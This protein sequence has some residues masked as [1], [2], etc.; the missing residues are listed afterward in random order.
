MSGG[1][2]GHQREDETDALQHADRLASPA[3][4]QFAG[5]PGPADAGEHEA[6][7]HRSGEQHP[8]AG[9]LPA[10]REHGEHQ[11]QQRVGL[12]VEARTEAAREP[13]APCEPAIDAVEHR[14]QGRDRHR[15]PRERSVRGLQAQ[16][17]QQ[18]DARR[19]R[20]RDTVGRTERGMRMTA[21]EALAQAEQQQRARRQQGADCANVSDSEP[22][23]TGE[24]KRAERTERNGREHVSL[25][26]APAQDIDRVVLAW[27]HATRHHDSMDTRA[28]AAF[29]VAAP[30]RGEIR[31]ET[32]PAPKPDEVL[33]RTLYSGI[34]RG[35]ES[36][37]FAGRVPRSEWNRMRAPFQAGEFPAPVKYGY[38]SVGIVEQGPAG[39]E[40]ETVFCLFPHQTRYVVPARAVHR[41]PRG[42][43]APRAVLAANAETAINGLWDAAV[44]PGDRVRVIGAGVVGCL[45][46]WLAGRIPGCEVQLIDLQAARAPIAAALGVEFALPE[47]AQADADV[48][49]HASGAPEG[50]ALA[51]R[52]AAFEA[53]IVE[54][55]WYGDRVAPLALGEAFHANRLQLRS[56]QVGRVAT[57]QRARWDT[58]RR[59]A[60]ALR[61]LAEGAATDAL[62]GGDD[63]FDALPQVMTRLAAG[64]GAT[65][66]HRIRYQE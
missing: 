60:L 7:A 35:T 15:A 46:A 11:D 42:L 56:S 1:Q 31:A 61:L 38:A 41:L 43:P 27:L 18:A 65:L 20:Q 48:V 58:D 5:E 45:V 4:W 6:V 51:M 28:A 39:L 62:L 59:M 55:S 13:A 29:W 23:R 36:L 64:P 21:D 57:V 24:Q 66:C 63:P 26:R 49:I 53:A 17:R 44:Q 3:G 9:A 34:S 40:G 47:Q 32:L 19:A 30:G 16:R 2:P 33:V 25:Q 22:D 8:G 12:H 10:P 14:G 50:L 54:M 52:L 37:V